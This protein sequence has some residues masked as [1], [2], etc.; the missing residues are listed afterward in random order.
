MNEKET[1]LNILKSDFEDYNFEKN[2]YLFFCKNVF[3]NTG[4]K[5]I[6]KIF[7]KH[8]RRPWSRR[9]LMEFAPKGYGLEIG[10]GTWT[11][12]PS[13]RT[14]LSDAYSSHGGSKSL[15]KVFFEATKIPYE[16]EMFTFIHSEHV[17]EHIYDPIKT[18]NEWKR[19]LMK[20]GKIILFLPHAERTFDSKRPRTTIDD[21]QNRV[22]G[23]ENSIKTKILR[24]WLDNVINKRLASHYG[25]IAPE[26][27]LKDGT[28]HYNVWTPCDIIQLLEDL[29]FKICTSYDVVVDRK[30]SFLVVA[31]KK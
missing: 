25:H 22:T 9:K 21:L 6:Y 26:D 2:D 13:D 14:V 27:M 18:L 20:N 16:K 17:L 1:T 11:I 29:N 19:L 31:E 5:V 12:A 4:W 28:I 10:C 7:H 24:E 15:A 30:D 8:I 23:D 3:K